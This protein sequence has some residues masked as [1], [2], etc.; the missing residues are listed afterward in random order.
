MPGEL[1]RVYWDSCVFIHYFQGTPDKI[2]VISE[3]LEDSAK[4]NGIEIVTSVLS[5]VEAAFVEDE[6][7]NRALDPVID[8]KI[9]D[10][11]AGGE[12]VKLVEYH[13]L[14]SYEARKL[15]RAVMATGRS[16]SPPDA[17]HVATAKRMRVAEF[18]TYD[19]PLTG[20]AEEVG[21]TICAPY[22]LSPRLPGT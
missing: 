14:I 6:K 17:I 8:Q 5:I 9:D 13:L 2:D 10:F 22:A 19:G 7:T 3:L 12:A 20:K 18:H 21:L 15:V 11:W 1:R 4:K 16:L